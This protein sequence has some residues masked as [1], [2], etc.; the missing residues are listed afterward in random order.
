MKTKTWINWMVVLGLLVASFGVIPYT[1]PVVQA[2]TIVRVIPGG[3]TSAGCGST[4]ATACELQTALTGASA[5]T[6]IWVAAGTYKPG[7]TRTDTFQLKSGVAFFGGFA[8][9]ETSR[10]QRDWGANLTVLSGDIGV[11]G[12]KSDNSY[13]VVTGSGVDATTILDGFTVSGGNTPLYGGGM[14]NFRGSPSLANVIFSDNKAAYGGAGMRNEKSSPSLTN[15]TFSGN[16]AG[17]GWGGGMSNSES[18]PILTNVT[19]SGN[20]AYSGAGMYNGGSNPDLTNV[21]FKRNSAGNIGGGIFNSNS[22]PLMTNVTFGS[23]LANNYGA[24]IYNRISSNP[25]IVNSILWGNTVQY[26]DGPQIYN[27]DESAPIILYSDIQGGCSAIPGNDCSGGGNID[28]NPLFSREL[29]DLEPVDEDYGDLHLRSE[30]PAID[31][32]DNT[33]PGLVGVTTDLGGKPRFYDVPGIAD[34]G[35]GPAPVIDMGA[36]EKQ[37]NDAPSAGNDRYNTDEGVSL[38]ISA[39]GVLTNDSDPDGDQLTAVLETGPANGSLTLNSNG[40]F[41]YLPEKD[42]IGEVTFTYRASGGLLVSNIASVTITVSSIQYAPVA[43]QDIYSTTE[44]TSLTVNSP[45]VL[46]NDSDLNG[47]ALSA[48]L[49]SGP[50]KGSLT[51]N[52]DGSFEYLPGLYNYG[53]VT[54]TYCAYDG[55]LQSNTATVTITVNNVNDAPVANDD[56][57]ITPENT[58][59]TITAPGV[60]EN[61]IERDDDPFTAVLVNGPSSG[62]L[63]LNPEGSFNYIPEKDVRGWISFNYRA[64]DGV[65]F[66][67]LATVSILIS[68]TKGPPIAIDDHYTITKNTVLAVDWPGVLKNDIDPYG[69]VLS[70][71]LESEPSRGSLSLNPAGDFTY[72]PETDFIGT[73]K[74]TYRAESI[75][76]ISNIATVTIAIVEGSDIYLP[77]VIR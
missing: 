65:L 71:N 19:F 34:T 55:Q 75:E 50:N 2:A 51:L 15:V 48:I 45:G 73:V 69:G 68:S 27:E 13:S 66:S 43:V 8:G 44:N 10:E 36:Y 57:Y 6:E 74:F 54:F 35:L 3:S 37:A 33:A 61:D 1:Q 56:N 24:G 4:W 21:V 16:D 63:T 30:S 52:P 32:G 25:I 67:N 9:T 59:L 31:A 76:L 41:D 47:D 62:I 49:E 46:E 40:S 38:H 60:L 39:P 17:M 11:E 18:N 7:T 28:I 64:T 5:G 70:A 58:K 77:L 14:Y 42:Y 26:K 72:L 29:G 23:N 22:S 53:D 20:K 12:D